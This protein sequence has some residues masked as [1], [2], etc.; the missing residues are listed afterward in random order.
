M[1]VDRDRILIFIP[2]YNCARQVPR[3]LAQLMHLPQDID[4]QVLVLDNQSPDDTLERASQA[5]TSLPIPA[6]VGRNRGNFGL[7]GSH[8][9]AFTHAMTHGFSHVVVLHGDDQGSIADLVPHLQAGRHREFDALLGA[10][11][12]KGS[13]LKGYSG[14]R[15]F[16]NRVYNL[17]FS[18]VAGQRLYDLG[19]G[20]NIYKTSC[21][22]KHDWSRFAN[23]LTF[24]YYLVL[25]GAAWGWNTAFFPI[26]WREDDQVSNV[27]LF[28]QAR[29]TAG[30]LARFAMN[31]KAFLSEQHVDNPPDRYAFDVVATHMVSGT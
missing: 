9:T 20:L 21:L 10:R 30:L 3:V 24:N 29:Q 23:D 2:A 6:M 15:T 1:N 18:A 4:F 27:K 12:M 14:F 22:A 5:I 31:R 11:F 16:G 19:S 8:K 13:S 28:K 26:S 17:A 7:G 25:A